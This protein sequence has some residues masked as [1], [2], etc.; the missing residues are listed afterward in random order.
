M[1]PHNV[2]TEHLSLSSR[3]FFDS[4]ASLP[5]LE[6]TRNCGELACDMTSAL[7]MAHAMPLQVLE[8]AEAATALWLIQY[9][10][11]RTTTA[12]AHADHVKYPGWVPGLP[13]GP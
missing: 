7:H 11:A 12:A 6:Y 8:R 1:L 3:P 2:L 5:E 9:G 10:Q 4:R 13:E